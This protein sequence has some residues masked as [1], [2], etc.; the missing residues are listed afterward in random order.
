MSFCNLGL[1]VSEQDSL[2]LKRLIR[3]CLD[4]LVFCERQVAPWMPRRMTVQ[5]RAEELDPGLE[6]LHRLLASAPLW[7]K[8]R[9]S[10]L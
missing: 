1:C 9:L 4:A 7:L 6:L 10:A 8:A 5:R 2:G 3:G